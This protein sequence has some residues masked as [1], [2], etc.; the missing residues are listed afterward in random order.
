MKAQPPIPPRTPTP[1]PGWPPIH[2]PSA[3]GFPHSEH[4]V[5]SG[6]QAPRSS[7]SGFPRWLSTL[8]GASTWCGVW[9]GCHALSGWKGLLTHLPLRSLWG[10]P[11]SCLP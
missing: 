2:F 7:V 3:C 5:Q 11:V 1:H 10:A 8:P 9:A 6:R 4:L